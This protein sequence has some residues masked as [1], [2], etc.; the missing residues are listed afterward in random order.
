MDGRL[1]RKA[2][3]RDSRTLKLAKYLTEKLPNPPAALDW[4]QGEDNWGIMLNDN[5][6]DCTI[7]ACGHAI[8]VWSRQVMT[9]Y[10]VSDSDILAAYELW[11]GYDPTNP[12]TD[13]GGVELDVLN[14]WRNL[15]LANHKLFGFAEVTPTNLLEVRQA[16]NLF[17]GVYI[18]VELPKTAQ[19][20]KIWD[21]TNVTSNNSEPDS[22]GGHCVFVT[23]YD[24]TSFTCITWGKL[25]KMTVPFWIKYVDEVYAVFGADWMCGYGQAPSGF[26]LTQLTADLAQI[27]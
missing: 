12:A 19:K 1:G 7:A 21:V 3:K 9:K 2:I 27:R 6:G 26:D 4:S 14:N 8:Q 18:G 22:W 15:G 13:D 25:K 24:E 10:T 23:G 20:Q 17:G 16:I 11:D 5:L